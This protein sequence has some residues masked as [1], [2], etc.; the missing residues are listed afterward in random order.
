MADDDRP[1]V[2]G[3]IA[4]VGVGL[5][6]GLLVAGAA[7]AATQVLGLG[8]DGGSGATSASARESMVLPTPTPTEEPT[9]PLVTLAPDPE[10]SATAGLAPSTP[11]E[12]PT[13][14]AAITLTASTTQAR[15][16]QPITLSGSYP[17]GEGATLAVERFVGGTWTSFVDVTTRVTGG[18]F[19]TFIRT[20]QTG[21]STFRVRD[22]A[23]DVASNEVKFTVG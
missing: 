23:T 20:S 5:V 22:L 17:A 14:S 7:L 19:S 3:L 11:S 15:P 18:T 8:D 6:V 4:L 16:G 10:Q 12:A 9:G 2:T 13:P 21:E 1:V